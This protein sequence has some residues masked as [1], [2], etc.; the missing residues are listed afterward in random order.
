MPVIPTKSNRKVQRTIDK[1]AYA[2]RNRIERFFNKIKHSRRVATRYDKLASR[3][4]PMLDQV[5][6]H[7]LGD[8]GGTRSSCQPSAHCAA[9]CAIAAQQST[10]RNHSAHRNFGSLRNP[11]R[12][13]DYA[14]A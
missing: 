12:S 3:N 11:L 5:C 2:M 8:V 1:T 6:P 4:D 9:C 13:F 14:S 7:G 10:F